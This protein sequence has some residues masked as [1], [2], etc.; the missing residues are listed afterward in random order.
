MTRSCAQCDQQVQ[1]SRLQLRKRR[2]Y[3]W[4]MEDWNDLRLVL[5]VARARLH[6]S[7]ALGGRAVGDR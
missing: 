5:A 1:Q 6:P 7:K 2:G 4:A 3:G